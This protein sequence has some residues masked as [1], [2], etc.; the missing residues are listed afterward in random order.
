MLKQSLPPIVGSLFHPSYMMVNAKILGALE[1]PAQCKDPEYVPVD[2]FE[3][4]PAEDYLSSFGL[5]SASLGIV[6]LSLGFCYSNGLFNVV[7]QAYGA[8]NYQLVGLYLNRMLILSTA[9][10]GPVL[11]LLQFA[12][13]PFRYWFGLSEA[14]AE[15]AA[16]YIRI[17]TPS[18]LF[19]VWGASYW[20]LVAAIG[21][22]QYGLY[23]MVIASVSHWTLAYVLAVGCG[24]KMVGVAIASSVQFVIR[25]VVTYAL[26]GRSADYRKCVVPLSDPRSRAG[27]SEMHQLGVQN[28]TLKVMGWWAF[29]VLT[30]M[31][32]GLNSTPALAGQTIL[33]NIGLYTFMIPVGLSQAANYLIGKQIGRKRADLAAKAFTLCWALTLGWA[34][35]SVVIVWAGENAIVGFYTT[36]EI[37]KEA[38][39]PA[40]AVLALFTFFDC[41]QIVCASAIGGLGM[42]KRIRYTT[43]VS[44][45]VF[46]LPLALGVGVYGGAKLQGLWYGPTLA[47]LLNYIFYEYVIRSTDWEQQAQ[48]IADRME[49]EKARDAGATA[50][51]E[52][53]NQE[54]SKAD[55][56]TAEGDEGAKE[57]GETADDAPKSNTI[58]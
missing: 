9:I 12:Y 36:A 56:E 16:L 58:N 29:E 14:Q 10:F 49:A 38:I 18:M 43:L 52:L 26:L 32:A 25:F 39:H 8:G 35:L 1:L 42:V 24:W 3:C 51:A 28:T 19:Y 33:R 22:P 40:W 41:M 23:S 13:Y 54:K 27:L 2:I 55:G 20:S 47:C 21:K 46:G 5:A 17:M 7:P 31:A 6:L 30:L 4:L 11:V 37:V 57:T 34:I 53:E 44:Y 48:A 45:W 15:L 50:K